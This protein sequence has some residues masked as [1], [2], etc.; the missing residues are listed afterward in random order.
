MD[1]NSLDL[2]LSS[3]CCSVDNVGSVTGRATAVRK[4]PVPFIPPPSFSTGTN[5]NRNTKPI[6][7]AS[8]SPSQKTATGDARDDCYCM[9]V[10]GIRG[11]KVRV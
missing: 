1:E 7:N 3:C 10:I 8:I 6:C 9:G 5:A 2:L 11:G 4:N